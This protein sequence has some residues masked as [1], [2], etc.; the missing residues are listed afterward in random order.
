MRTTMDIDDKLLNGAKAA[1]GAKTKKETVERSLQEV[2]RRQ[3]IQALL[4]RQGKGFGLSLR[5][6]YRTRRDE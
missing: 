2:I 1:L 3:R 4:D 6:L 5:E